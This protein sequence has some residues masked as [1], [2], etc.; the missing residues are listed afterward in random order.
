MDFETLTQVLTQKPEHLFSLWDKSEIRELKLYA[1]FFLTQK[2]NYKN[3]HFFMENWHNCEKAILYY[4][5]ILVPLWRIYIPGNGDLKTAIS[6][7]R[8]YRQGE[9]FLCPTQN[10]EEIDIFSRLKDLS[11][12]FFEENTQE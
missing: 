1:D 6:E 4:Y 11:E 5:N 10:E 2:D 9:G 8:A 3:H 7:K 12:E